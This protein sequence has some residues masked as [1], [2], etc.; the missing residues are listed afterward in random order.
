MTVFSHNT[1]FCYSSCGTRFIPK[2]DMERKWVNPG[3]MLNFVKP[4][5]EEEDRTNVTVNT[6]HGDIF[7]QLC[8]KRGARVFNP[9]MMGAGASEDYYYSNSHYKD[10]AEVS[11]CE[12]HPLNSGAY[13]SIYDYTTRKS[14]CKKNVDFFKASK[15]VGMLLLASSQNNSLPET[16]ILEDLGPSLLFNS[17]MFYNRYHYERDYPSIQL[18]IFDK[19]LL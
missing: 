1:G 8:Y 16:Q 12:H 6:K 2:G 15:G 4:F 10:V 7:L 19:E 9:C 3:V 13:D 11:W 14:T 18:F 17:G 5:E